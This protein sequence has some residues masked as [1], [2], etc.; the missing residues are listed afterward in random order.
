MSS[1]I[2]AHEIAVVMLAGAAV[3]GGLI[4]VDDLLRSL[5]MW[6]LAG[7]LSSSPHEPFQ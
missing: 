4:G 2:L 5:F 7:G 1:V 6:Q 3:S